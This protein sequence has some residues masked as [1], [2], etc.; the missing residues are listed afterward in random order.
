[1]S[2]PAQA[3][4]ALKAVVSSGFVRVDNGSHRLDALIGRV[5]IGIGQDGLHQLYALTGDR[6]GL[7][8]TEP[9]VTEPIA[10]VMAVREAVDDDAEVTR[11]LRESQDPAL[12][13]AVRLEALYQLAGSSCSSVR[14]TLFGSSVAVLGAFEQA[15]RDLARY[16]SERAYLDL[17][18]S[19]IDRLPPDAFGTGVKR[20]QELTPWRHQELTPCGDGVVLISRCLDAVR[21]PARRF[22][23]SR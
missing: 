11:L 1:M 23:L 3:E 17:L 20:H 4:A 10:P 9:F 14:G 13:R 21:S 6:K 16:P 8:A 15:R 5:I 7:A 2:Q 12:P 19:T 22:S 18:S